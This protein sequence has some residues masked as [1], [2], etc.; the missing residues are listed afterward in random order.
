MLYGIVR[1]QKQCESHN[2]VDVVVDTSL[3]WTESFVNLKSCE[4]HHIQTAPGDHWRKSK[5]GWVKLNTDGAFLK[6]INIAA[7]EDVFRDHDGIGKC[8][9]TMRIEKDSALKTKL[10]VWEL[11]CYLRLIKQL[12]CRDWKVRLR[13][14]LSEHNKIANSMAKFDKEK[15]DEM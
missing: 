3:A 9:F 6:S 13:H 14:I 8:G 7:T 2:I 12:L 10:M 15:Y 5:K 1:S 4:L 11:I